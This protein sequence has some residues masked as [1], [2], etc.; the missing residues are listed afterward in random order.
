VWLRGRD[1]A[2]R[3]HGD[4]FDLKA[5]HEYALALGPMGLDQLDAELARF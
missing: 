2:R 5:F 1:D 3:R 4:A